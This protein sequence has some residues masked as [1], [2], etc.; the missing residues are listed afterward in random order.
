M[1]YQKLKNPI[2][3]LENQVAE[4]SEKE[5]KDMGMESRRE[6]ETLTG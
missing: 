1:Y 2:E 4:I 6:K 3:V 5:H